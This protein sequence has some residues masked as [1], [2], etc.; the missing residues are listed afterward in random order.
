MVKCRPNASLV[1]AGHSLTNSTSVRMF[2]RHEK[3]AEPRVE[4]QRV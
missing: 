1:E 3:G 2:S 4:K